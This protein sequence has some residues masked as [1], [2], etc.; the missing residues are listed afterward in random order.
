M[1]KYYRI[2][3]CV[4]LSHVLRKFSYDPFARLEPSV[5]PQPLLADELKHIHES[6]CMKACLHRTSVP[7][8]SPLEG[9]LTW[10]TAHVTPG[11]ALPEV[12]YDI[13]FY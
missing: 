4:A 2:S 9:R 3:E 10:D 7:H 12:A 13:S 5:T 1:L 6:T 8:N 11:K